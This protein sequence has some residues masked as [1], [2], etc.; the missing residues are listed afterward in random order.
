MRHGFMYVGDGE[1]M[2]H[3]FV[4][5]HWDEDADGRKILLGFYLSLGLGI[6]SLFSRR[7]VV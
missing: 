4:G 6:I 2:L 3:G 7:Q 5:L 1:L